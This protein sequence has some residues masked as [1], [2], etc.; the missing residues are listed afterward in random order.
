M[1]K[2]HTKFVCQ[3]CG[4]ESA[5]YLGRCPDCGEW[6]SLVETVI[7]A[8]GG[9]SGAGANGGVMLARGGQAVAIP[10]PQVE[11]VASR[12]QASGSPE[13][14]RVLGGGIVPGSMV[15]LAGEPGIG[16]SSLML[17]VAGDVALTT[18]EVLYVSA[19][20]SAQQV[21]LRAER[22]GI[23]TERLLLLPETELEAIV[24]IAERMKPALIVVDSIQTVASA[25]IPAA[26]GSI[27]QVRDCTLRLMR[28]AK[29]SHV[30][31]CIIGHVTK[32]G[33][34]AGPRALEH[35]VDAV[36]YLEGERFHSYRLLRGVKNRFGAT[37]EVG[38]FEMRGEG[39]VD[40][41][42][43]SA[44]FLADHSGRHSGSAV[45]VSMEGTRPLLVEVQALAATTS[46]GMPRCTT[47][48]LDHNRVLMLLAV[49]TK[50]VGLA[51]ANQDVYVNVAGG[52]TL[53]EPAVDLGVAAAIA[54]SFRERLVSPETVL[55]GEVG[56]GGELRGV[57]RVE[58]RVREA[59]KLGF[60]RVVLPRSGAAGQR[61]ELAATGA[62]AGVE[63]AYAA[64]LADALALALTEGV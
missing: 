31:I 49:L 56:L 41:E 48:G 57:T 1:P 7:A 26:P 37:H 27:S 11:A 21:K 50:R 4:F 23:S 17:Q 61:G 28:L 34:V 45:I 60:K 47:N 12:R 35:I 38:V 46:F 6:N 32:E 9:R 43:P 30:P 29:G 24:E 20:E 19:E 39:M 54:S 44:L 18:G 52:F 63:L 40:V 36:L 2:T 22:L 25:Q 15:L 51:L 3:Q 64:T 8:S 33:T 53:D 55:I 42:N 58:S 14:D 16:K 59:G 13:L 5:K 62:S 10:L